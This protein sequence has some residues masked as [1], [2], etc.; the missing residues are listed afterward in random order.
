[1]LRIMYVT[2]IMDPLRNLILPRGPRSDDDTPAPIIRF[3]L[4]RL[5]LHLGLIFISTIIICSLEVVSTRL[6]IQ[7]NH[8]TSGFSPIA[9]EEDLEIVNNAVYSGTEE[10]VIGCVGLLLRNR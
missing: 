8:A 5:S 4:A 9:E 10:D 7:R 1:M 6:S 3:T 2:L